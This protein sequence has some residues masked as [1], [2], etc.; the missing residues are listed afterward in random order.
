M[1]FLTDHLNFIASM[2]RVCLVLL[3]IRIVVQPRTLQCKAVQVFPPVNFTLTVSALAQV[4]L[5]WKLS[6]NQEQKNY[7]IRYD[8]K[9]LTPVFEEYDTMKTHSLQTAVLHNGFSAHVRT[10]LFHQGLQ[11]TSD[12]V[13]AELQP[14][15]GAENTAVTDLSCVTHF[16][17]SSTVSLHCTWLPGK[18]APEDTEYFLFYRYETYMEECQHY[19]KDKWNRNTECRFSVTRIVPGEI[20]ELIVIHINGSSKYAAIKPFQQL[21]NQNAIEKVNVPRN[22]T[23]F[24]EQNDLVATWEK[25]L[26][27]FPKGCFEYEFYLT[28]LKSGNKQVSK[29]YSHDFRLR[30]DVTCRYSIQIRANHY[31]CAV[32]GF[33]SDWSEILY[34][35]ENKQE[36]LIVWSL[37]VL[38]VSTCC[39]VT[40]IAI[41]CKSQHTWSKLFPPI[42]TPRIKFRDPFPNHYE[43]AC[44]CP[45]ET[46]LEPGLAE[47]LPS[48]TLHDDVF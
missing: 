8:V 1:V 37:A 2:M 47:G 30:I 14:P 32:N 3:W 6:P 46:W 16:T 28:N 29:T 40:L 12:W 26:S 25:P 42:P 22:V 23:V 39:T 44:S 33:W 43:R 21:F 34:V 24:L 11:M 36:N 35:G 19:I 41:V 4:L 31:M 20:D 48:S 38:C 18:G 10:L 9:I 15:P 5:S 17:I 13:T 7:T 27:T 45:S